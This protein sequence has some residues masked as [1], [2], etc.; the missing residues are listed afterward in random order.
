MLFYGL[1]HLIFRRLGLSYLGQRSVVSG[2]RINRLATMDQPLEDQRPAKRPKVVEDLVAGI[3]ADG[4]GPPPKENPGFIGENGGDDG[5]LRG[6][7]KKNKHM[8]KRRDAAG[9]AKSRKGKEKD[10]RN[11][12]RRGRRGTRNEEAHVGEGSVEAT[13]DQGLEQVQKA[14]RLPKRQ[15]ALLIGF[16]GMGCSGM[17]MYM[18]SYSPIHLPMLNLA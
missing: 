2:K 3:D 12:G 1:Y 11:A 4:Q 8:S 9:Y 14:P 7:G 15:C 16:C 5:N 10:G 18:F 13:G 17:Q 6:V